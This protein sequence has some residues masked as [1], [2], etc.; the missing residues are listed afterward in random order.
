MAPSAFLR[1]LSGFLPARKPTATTPKGA[2]GTDIKSGGN[3]VHASSHAP[4]PSAVK[5]PA[6]TLGDFTIDEDR[7]IKVVAIGAGYSGITAAIRFPQ[8]IKNV[9][10]TVYEKNAGVGGTWYSNK[11]PGLSCDIPSHCY[12]FTF[13]ANTEWSS[14]Y[15]PAPEIRAYLERIVDKYK[16][17]K[18]IKLQHELIH[19]RYDES[20]G[21]WHLKLRRPVAE[22][23][24]DQPQYEEIEDTAD[25]VLCGAGGLSRWSWPDI[26]G[27]KSF[28]GKL[29]H[30]ADWETDDWKE[31]VKDWGD[32]RVGVIGVGSSALQ[33]VPALQPRV[34]KLF[35]FVRGKTWLATPFFSEKLA[36][37]M[38]RDP[39]AANYSFGDDDKKKFRD[40]PEFYKAFR[41]ELEAE[42]NSVHAYTLQ[43]SDR[44]VEDQRVFKEAMAKRLEK[45][46]W[47]AD[48]I[49]PDF[50]VACRRL[51]PGPGYLEALCEENV[52]FVPK[53]IRRV[54]PTG[55]ETTDGQH[56][57]LDVLICATGY[58]TDYKFPFPVIGR[59]GKTLQER[60]TPHPSTYLSLCT[61]GF[62]NWFNC[63][64]P[65]SGV[66]SGS[67]LILIEREIEYAVNVVG[68]MQRERLKSIEVKREAVDDF[69]EYLEA[70]FP[71]TVYSAKCR[72]WYK[73]GKEEGRVVGLWPG[74]CLHAV[75]AFERPRWEDFDY[76]HLNGDAKNRFYWLGEG[77]TYEE[78]HMVGDRAWYLSD[79]EVDF[80][81]GTL[82]Y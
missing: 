32:K 28:K 3:G 47:I 82:F 43:N 48:H 57:E 11:Y 25:F 23:T 51:T 38:K 49:V 33:M 79:K 18:Y 1:T 75:R 70:Y 15:A 42:L 39:K 5:A 10:L 81:P 80:P 40:D 20:S 68:K 50:P 54:T 14:F 37:L 16:L 45:K 62:P 34:G 73:M 63:L 12:Q 77:C 72:S 46:P 44:Q 74:S 35:N 78:K 6:F 26:E 36:D 69:D 61:D 29:L 30:S 66:G 64:G 8:R 2:N 13:E 58:D 60:Y 59:S 65:N 31:G 17:S 55:L 9:E 24:S 71:G 7:P 76:E 52:D 21:K 27:L 4:P 19:A 53:E 41:H 56:Y 22:S 67:L